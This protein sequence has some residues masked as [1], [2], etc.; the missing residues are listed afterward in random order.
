MFRSQAPKHSKNV[1]NRKKQFNYA[2]KQSKAR[3][4]TTAFTL[5]ELLVVIA[6]IG[7]LSGLI[8]TTMGGAT[9]SARIAKL[10]VY[11]NSMR[12][13]LGANLVSEWKFDDASTVGKD[14]WGGNSGTI[15]GHEP[16]IISNS[17]CISGSCL[18]FT[19]SNGDYFDCGNKVSLQSMAKIT[20][21]TWVNFSEPTGVY[22]GKSIYNKGSNT[23]AGTIW[24]YQ[25]I[26]N[27]RLYFEIDTATPYYAWTPILNKWY[28]LVV[29]YDGS[30]V[31]YYIDGAWAKASPVGVK[32][33]NNTNLDAYVGGYVGSADH[34]LF[35]GLIDEFRIYN[36]SLPA[37]Q[38]RENY[39]AGLN[40]LLA[41]NGITQKE[42]DQRLVEL[43]NSVA[44]Q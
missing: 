35:D 42:Y 13:V 19:A 24:L 17:S 21:S 7:I 30:D 34:H 31:I 5:I 39:L 22:N 37:S 33:I 6:I 40:K 32:T 38:V 29:I 41:N 15:V 2:L 12:D 27:N 28:H 14:T 1:N 36:T 20:I 4:R 9:E 44:Q 8:I 26:S 11:S 25:N 23:V 3:F 16:D 18:K 43:N 10:K